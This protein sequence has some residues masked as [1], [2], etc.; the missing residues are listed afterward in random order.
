M[1]LLEKIINLLKCCHKNKVIE[2]AIE[3]AEES[4]IILHK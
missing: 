4:N 2:E 3:V 1:N